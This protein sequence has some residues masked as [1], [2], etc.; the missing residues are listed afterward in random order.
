MDL[1][2]VLAL[3]S[4]AISLVNATAREYGPGIRPGGVANNPVVIFRH[5]LVDRTYCTATEN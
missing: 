1:T 2:I 5:G 4:R 3:H